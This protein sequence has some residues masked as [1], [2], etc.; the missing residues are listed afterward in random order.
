MISYV[1]FPL[2]FTYRIL[3]F[4]RVTTGFTL[5]HFFSFFS[6]QLSISY[7]PC[8]FV[9][10]IPPQIASVARLVPGDSRDAWSFGL[11]VSAYEVLFLNELIIIILAFLFWFKE[12]KEVTKSKF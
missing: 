5:Q 1:L 10:P 8:T 7:P 12:V 4:E 9:L 11:V 3:Y 2:P 6:F